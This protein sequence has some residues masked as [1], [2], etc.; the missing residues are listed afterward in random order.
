MSL[1]LPRLLP[2][3]LGSAGGGS[4]D[5][6]TEVAAEA[7]CSVCWGQWAGLGAAARLSRGAHW[8]AGRGGSWDH[9]LASQHL[10]SLQLREVQ[11]AV[12]AH[13]GQHPAVKT[14]LVHY[15]HSALCEGH[16]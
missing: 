1:Q 15:S 14:G 5:A 10:L 6:A 3:V 8:P 7:D 2:T 9:L 4:K 13:M 11:G 16:T 12:K